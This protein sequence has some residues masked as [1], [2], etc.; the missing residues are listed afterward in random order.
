V[1][2]FATIVALATIVVGCGNSTARRGTAPALTAPAATAATRT[3][4]TPHVSPTASVSATSSSRPSPSATV[5]LAPAYAS[6]LHAIC[7][8][9]SRGDAAGV[10]A[11][12]MHYQYNSGLRWGMFGDGEGTTSDPSA[13]YTWLSGSHVVCR[14]E[15]ANAGGH[16][17]LLTSGWARPGPWSLLDLD[18]LNG[19]WVINDFTFGAAR[20]LARAMHG[21]AQP[22]MRYRG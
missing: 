10:N 20:P 18:L 8:A 1:F 21:V 9:L 5:V 2:R 12:L 4:P 13:M 19:Q 3:A 7:H 14:A 22:V 11:H 17:S 6:F 16:A 15:S